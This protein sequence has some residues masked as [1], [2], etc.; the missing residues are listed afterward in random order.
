MAGCRR[1]RSRQVPE[2]RVVQGL[3]IGI[4]PDSTQ[5]VGLGLAEI[6]DIDRIDI[7]DIHQMGFVGL[8]KVNMQVQSSGRN[9]CGYGEQRRYYQDQ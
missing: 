2:R 1:E 4:V 5:D 9:R 6:P 3:D 8:P 7:R